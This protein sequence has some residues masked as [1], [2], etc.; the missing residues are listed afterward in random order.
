MYALIDPI[1]QVFLRE[2]NLQIDYPNRV[3]FH[4]IQPSDLPENVVAVQHLPKPVVT[5]FQVASLGTVLFNTNNQTWEQV[6][7][8]QEKALA[9]KE[10]ALQKMKDQKIQT[11]ERWWYAANLKF[12]YE[13]KEIA[14]DP[15]STDSLFWT[16]GHVATQNALP[17]NWP[18]G[19]KAMDNTYVSIPDVTVW[20]AF[21]AAMGARGI[22]NFLRA[23]LLKS[24]V[25]AV[26]NLETAISDL[27]L[28]VW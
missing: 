27:D 8:I 20:N 14:C 24:Q 25:Q 19:W 26:N 18:G 21:Y 10:A 6:W 12:E 3:F 7:D 28:I 17:A 13:G 23:Q 16:N 22:T 2:V 15:R 5:D 9:D 1:N 4:P 11:I